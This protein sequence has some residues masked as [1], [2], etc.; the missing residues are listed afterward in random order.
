MTLPEYIY[1]HL[2][3]PFEWWVHDCVLF[4]GRWAEMSSGKKYIPEVTW[5]NR[6][7]ANEVLGSMG[8]IIAAFDNNF[9]RIE[10]NFA[11]DGYLAIH[12]GTAHIFSGSH[13]VGHGMRGL[14]FKSRMEAECAYSY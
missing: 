9:T 2:N 6:K 11:R 7:E 1:M 12:N 4:A 14:V 10:P 5:T 8:G 3:T 13:I